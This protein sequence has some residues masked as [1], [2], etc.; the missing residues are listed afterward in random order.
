MKEILVNEIFFLISFEML[1][2]NMVFIYLD[3]NVQQS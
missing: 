1:I 3:I 2:F